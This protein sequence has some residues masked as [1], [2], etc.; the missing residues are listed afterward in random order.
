MTKYQKRARLL[1]SIMGVNPEDKVITP[2]GKVMTSYQKALYLV[3]KY[4]FNKRIEKFGELT[5]C[6]SSESGLTVMQK[7]LIRQEWS[8]AELMK[9]TGLNRL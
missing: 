1:C 5:Q 3:R 2:K 7:P 9:A 6:K 4:T 8:E